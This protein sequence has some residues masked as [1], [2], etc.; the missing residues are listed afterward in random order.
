MPENTKG[1]EL[2]Q[3]TNEEDAYH[4]HYDGYELGTYSEGEL[5]N[6]VRLI[7]LTVETD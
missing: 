3:S 7:N 2:T 4:L 6:L 5:T 1:F